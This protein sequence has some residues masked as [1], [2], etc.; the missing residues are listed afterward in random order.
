MC[1]LGEWTFVNAYFLQRNDYVN[2]QFFSSTGESFYRLIKVL[3]QLKLVK[4]FYVIFFHIKEVSY[5]KF[6]RC[7]Q[8]VSVKLN[9]L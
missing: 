6:D 9:E 4:R 3:V 7:K 2:V 1:L 8:L 5:E